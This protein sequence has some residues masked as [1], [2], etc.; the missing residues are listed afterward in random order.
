MR[1][2]VYVWARFNDVGLTTGGVASS[3]GVGVEMV[4][5]GGGSRCGK[6]EEGIVG[7]VELRLLPPPPPTTTL[8]LAGCVSEK[9]CRG[10]GS[11]IGS[12]A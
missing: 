11:A 10:S 5:M 12:C 2:I 7:R 3:F 6:R 1:L 9:G 4:M 8:A